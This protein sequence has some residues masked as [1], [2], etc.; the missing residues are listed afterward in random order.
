MNEYQAAVDVENQV[1]DPEPRPLIL[2]RRDWAMDAGDLML[3]ASEDDMAEIGIA[4]CDILDEMEWLDSASCREY[5]VRSSARLA[6]V[7]THSSISVLWTY[8]PASAPT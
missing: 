3:P 8:R 4:L 7:V 6:R 2:S 5:R 1:N